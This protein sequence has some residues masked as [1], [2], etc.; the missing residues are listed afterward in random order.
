MQ[1]FK[2]T[3]EKI[4]INPFVFVPEEILGKIFEQAGK[5]KGHIPVW[6]KVN[7]EDYKQTLLR[8]KGAWRLYIN[9]SMLKNSPQR[10]G[11]MLNITIQFD[12][13]DRI[14]TPDNK[15]MEALNENPA[16]K[17]VFENL[18]P[19]KQKEIIR[20]I[21]FLKSEESI[22]RNVEKTIGFLLG[23]NRFIGRDKP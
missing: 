7:G 14:F 18:T 16:A 13:V 8:F 19:S 4:G 12:P 5:A 6:G 3:L 17:L 21:S 20:Y 10:I 11:E 9:T 1:R 15:L 22:K 23:K 2:A